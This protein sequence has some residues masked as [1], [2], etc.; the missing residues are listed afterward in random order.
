MLA[1]IVGERGLGKTC[2]GARQ[3]GAAL[4]AMAGGLLLWG[5]LPAHAAVQKFRCTNVASGAPWTIAVDLDRARVNTFPARIS[6]TWISWHDPSAG[7]FELERATGKL[8]LRN[9]SSTGGYFLYYAC[10]PE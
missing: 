9:A 7:Y 4:L 8:R 6:D 5:T 2:S 3:R 10:R 1:E